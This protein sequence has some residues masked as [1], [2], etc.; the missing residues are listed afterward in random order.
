MKLSSRYDSPD[1]SIGQCIVYRPIVRG[2]GKQALRAR[3]NVDVADVEHNRDSSTARLLCSKDSFQTRH[4]T[5]GSLSLAL[6]RPT[7]SYRVSSLPCLT[8]HYWY[9]VPM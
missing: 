9:D 3:T 2:G 1:G 6:L 5:K 4:K 7:K 8:M